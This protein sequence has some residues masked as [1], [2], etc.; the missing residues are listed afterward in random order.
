MAVKEITENRCDKI[1]I[2]EIL[3]R[4]SL[5]SK[6]VYLCR[7]YNIFFMK[8]KIA[9]QSHSL[10]LFRSPILFV[11][12][13]VF[14]IPVLRAQYASDM[15]QITESYHYLSNLL[16]PHYKED[17]TIDYY[18]LGHVL[19][20]DQTNN[21]EGKPEKVTISMWEK[22]DNDWETLQEKKYIYADGRLKEEQVWQHKKL[23]NDKDYP[24]LMAKS[25]H[26]FDEAERKDSI[27]TIMR[28]DLGS[29]RRDTFAVVNCLNRNDMLDSTRTYKATNGTLNLVGRSSI[30]Y[31]KDKPVLIMT[32]SYW[33]SG[34]RR[35][36]TDGTVEVF[37]ADDES[38]DE[39]FVQRQ[40][41]CI[42]NS[43]SGYEY[44]YMHGDKDSR[45]YMR[46]N[47]KL[48]SKGRICS[49]DVLMADMASVLHADYKYDGLQRTS[50]HK[51]INPAAL[52]GV[53]G[54]GSIKSMLGSGG[55]MYD[56]TYTDDG[57][58]KIAYY[59][60]S[61]RDGRF[62]NQ[63]TAWLQYTPSGKIA[64]SQTDSYD[65]GEFEDKV[66]DV[67][68]YNEKD[69]L[70]LILHYDWDK[71][72][73][74]WTLWTKYIYDYDKWGNRTLLQYY[75]TNDAGESWYGSGNTQ[76]T[77]DDKGHMLSEISYN[78]HKGHWIGK[79]KTL[80]T[81]TPTGKI[82][83]EKKYYWDNDYQK[84]W[85]KSAYYSISY[86]ENDSIQNKTVYE[87]SPIETSESFH[88]WKSKWVPNKASEF[89]YLPN[90]KQE[91]TYYWFKGVRVP[92]HQYK[93]YAEADSTSESVLE[94]SRNKS[95]WEDYRRD[96]KYTKG[97]TIEVK[98]I[99][100]KINNQFDVFAGYV[101][102]VKRIDL[103]PGYSNETHYTWDFDKKDW[104]PSKRYR[105]Y[106]DKEKGYINTVEVY[107]KASGTWKIEP[108][109]EEE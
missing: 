76:W 54:L 26:Y 73:N 77:Y 72:K 8:K 94:W 90:E 31:K 6:K 59:L 15:F 12:L 99:Y 53:A 35:E 81:Y 43:R 47:V 65:R 11:L 60:W 78:W 23:T 56:M 44:T 13:S 64:M 18:A 92:S 5:L 45:P 75:H 36:Y 9:Y 38:K 20:L 96:I 42:N 34:E 57:T 14:P 58:Q 104:M 48:D 46:Q 63:R 70:V 83:S 3:N 62:V 24:K 69:E 16:D 4:L 49:V 88:Y 67:K 17:G 19:R 79:S 102:V 93:S 28:P 1:I 55:F 74:D 98:E 10:F 100:D 106:Y 66:K 61:E 39:V 40:Y 84:D 21:P 37:P 91:T 108:E 103:A 22:Y 51:V 25:L 30:T 29:T 86:D 109:D 80:W 105:S 85:M 101:K 107:D 52:E 2:K 89:V 27:F 97:D 71:E 50:V 41:V 32:E 33:K 68:T 87:P 82:T 7:N 95:K